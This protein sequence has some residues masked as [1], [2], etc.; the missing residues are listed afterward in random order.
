MVASLLIFAQT[1]KL[2]R[3]RVVSGDKDGVILVWDISAEL[4]GSS[5][6]IA[7]TTRFEGHSATVEDVC[8]K[9]GSHTEVC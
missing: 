3:P 4:R 5:K 2:A 8:F 7:P 9:P 6:D 1:P